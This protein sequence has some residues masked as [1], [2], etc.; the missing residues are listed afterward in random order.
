MPC[1]EAVDTYERMARN[2][3]GRCGQGCYAF[4]RCSQGSL[5]GIDALRCGKAS[6]RPDGRPG[7]LGIPAAVNRPGGFCLLE[8][9]EQHV[10]GRGAGVLARVG[11]GW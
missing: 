4:H 6:G 11:L 7:R 10:G 8:F 1:L 2:A 5:K 3:P 9:D